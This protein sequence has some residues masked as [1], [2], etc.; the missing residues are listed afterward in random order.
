[1]AFEPLNPLAHSSLKAR[2]EVC[3]LPS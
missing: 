1:V 2:G 3:V